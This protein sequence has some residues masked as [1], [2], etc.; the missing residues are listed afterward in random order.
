[1]WHYS[2]PGDSTR[3]HP[4]EVLEETVAQWIKGITGPC[5]NPMGTKRV[6][7]YSAENKPRKL[8]W[9]NLHSPVPNGD[10]FDIGG[11]SEGGSIDSDYVDDS[12]ESEDDLDDSEELKQSLP[13]LELRSK[14]RH[15][16][17][18]SPSKTLASSSRNVKCDRAVATDFEEKAAK[19]PK[20][21]APKPQKALPRMRIVVPVTMAST[22][23]SSALQ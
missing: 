15:D 12:E 11:E 7:P 17:M 10:E 18:T 21:D 19:Q 14:H 9:T 13:R 23:T 1:M 6:A 8:E 4:E 2:G 5:D 22:S 3:S 16:P 20:P